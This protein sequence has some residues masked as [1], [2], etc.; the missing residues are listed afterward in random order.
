[1]KIA[2]FKVEDWFNK[3]EKGAKYDL[4]DT[5]IES[6]SIND[7]LDVVGLDKS[8]IEEVLSKK[9]SYGDIHGSTRLKTAISK[10]YKTQSL[11]NITITH[12][13]IGANHLVFLSII[14]NGDEIV[15]VLPTYQQHYSIP[16]SFGAVVKKVFLKPENNWIPDLDE[17]DAQVT[18]STKLIAINNPNNPTGSVIKDETMRKIVDIARKNDCYILCDEVYRG[19]VRNK[20]YE[21]TSIVDLYEKGISTSSLSKAFSL[22]GL[23]LGWVV[24]CPEVID[25]IN[26][27][28][29]Y[30]TISVG[31]LD[32][33]FASIAVENKDKIFERNIKKLNQGYKILSDWVESESHISCVLPNGGTTAFLQY[34]MDIPSVDL[35]KKLLDDTG[36][37][38]LPGETLEIENF[39]RIGYCSDIS[40]LQNGLKLLS[41]WLLKIYF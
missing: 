17:L 27:Q 6:M 3:Y 4:A 12:G 38:L 21:T 10:L 22:A 28:R 13:A 16:E 34:D 33:Y 24:G 25:K 29:E 19:I 35:C 20:E 41:D 31:V 18:P 37:L 11:E 36:V 40:R 1:M 39:V 5:C 15:S 32:D 14:G 2:K 30:N 8:L 26:H 7:L 23:R 9:L